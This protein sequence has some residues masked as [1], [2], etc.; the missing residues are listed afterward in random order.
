MK[1]FFFFSIKI[2]QNNFYN[3]IQKVLK[4]KSYSLNCW[5]SSILAAGTLGIRVPAL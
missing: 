4:L 1:M 5:I 3:R 2:V